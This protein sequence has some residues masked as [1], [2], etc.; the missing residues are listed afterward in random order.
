MKRTAIIMAAVAM[1]VLLS[2]SAALRAQDAVFKLLRYEWT[3]NPDGTRDYH[4]RHEVQ[5]LRNRALTAYADKGETFVVYNPDLEELTVNEV[6]TLR[7]DGGRVD[8]PQNAFIYQLP[9]ECADCGRFNHMRELAMVHTGME[10]GC[11]VVVDYTI[12]RRYDLVDLTLPLV[13]ECPVERLEVAVNVP[14]GQEFAARLDAGYEGYSFGTFDE[15]R[16]G[17][18]YRLVATGLQQSVAEPYLPDGFYPSLHLFN[19]TPEWYPAFDDERFDGAVEA[20]GRVMTSR[21]VRENLVAA[22]NYVV[23]NIH[24]NDIAPA[25]LGYTHATA[26]ETWQ[27][28][29]G[30][31]TDKAVLLAAILRSEG[32][33]AHVAGADADQVGV[34][35]D[36]L[37]YRLS[38]RDK[39]PLSL[40]AEA[41]DEETNV[42]LTR[43]PDF[44]PDTLSDGFFRLVLSPVPWAPAVDARRM[45]LSRRAPLA[46]PLCDI[47]IT[48]EYSLPKGMKLVGGKKSRSASH[49]GIGS[50]ELVVKQSGTTLKVTRRLKLQSRLVEPADYA[51]YR[52]LIATWQSLD[53]ILLQQ[54]SD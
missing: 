11:T 35:V 30:T 45:A 4:Y 49:D 33:S 38:L 20:M 36:T 39:S 34:I 7:A 29:C 43:R 26:A 13:R 5:I 2:P 22:R 18:N 6:Y 28:G 17:A 1:A 42:S 32:F 16:D 19:G 27:S 41:R 23:D 10:L 46:S 31:V 14:E 3:V 21:S 15:S 8:M 12:H 37:E 44:R 51:R 53:H 52:E 54:K 50:V 48:D 24:L 25:H 40:Y 9:A 47:D